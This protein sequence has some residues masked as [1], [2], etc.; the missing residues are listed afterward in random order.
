MRPQSVLLDKFEIEKVKMAF[1][2]LFSKLDNGISGIKLNEF[3]PNV[4]KKNLENTLKSGLEMLASVDPLET[5]IS[6][7]GRTMIGNALSELSIS[8]CS[9][10]IG[11]IIS[12]L[13]P[14]TTIP[15]LLKKITEDLEYLKDSMDVIRY[16]NIIWL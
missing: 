4:T 3:S 7:F 13:A 6:I 5:A 14:E 10:L 8:Q 12:S 2:N 11:M 1:P 16:D 15:L 9:G